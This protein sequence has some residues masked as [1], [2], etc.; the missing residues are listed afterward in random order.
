VA[1]VSDAVGVVS[2]GK[3]GETRQVQ[4]VAAGVVSATSTDAINGSQLYHTNAAVAANA[5][6]VQNLNNGAAGVVQYSNA[7][8]PATPNG[9]VPS[10]NVTLVG[11]DRSAPVAVH[12]VADGTAPTDAVN[13]NQLTGMGNRLGEAI[14]HIGNTVAD[15]GNQLNERIGDVGKKA[16]AGVAGAIA[17]SSIP[18]VTRPGATGL[19]VGSG[20]YGGQSAFALGVSSMSDN[21]N[22]IVKGNFSTNTNGHVGVGAGALYQW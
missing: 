8:S 20:Y 18:Q 16:N 19:G 13:V 5:A 11:A 4:N 22:W 9:G 10:N 17:Q 2:V 1:G 12:N 6:A 3:A 15:M 21:G 14:N 7:G